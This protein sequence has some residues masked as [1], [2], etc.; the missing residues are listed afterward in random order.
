MDH[1]NS[2]D[3]TPIAY[4]DAGD[5]P[6]VILSHGFAADHRLNWVLPGVVD[7]L[8]A[9]GRRVLAPDARGHGSSGSPMT[10][11]LRR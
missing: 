2:F 6:T 8:V 7:A 1:L 4:L 5:G 9:S 11:C 3:G 10:R